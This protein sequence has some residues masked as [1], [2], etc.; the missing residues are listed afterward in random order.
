[1]LFR[2]GTVV[3]V[4]QVFG[5]PKSL[6]AFIAMTAGGYNYQGVFCDTGYMYDYTVGG[7]YTDIQPSYTSAQI[8][9]IKSSPHLATL[10]DDTIVARL[11]TDAYCWDQVQALGKMTNR[12]PFF[13]DYAYFVDLSSTSSSTGYDYFTN[14]YIDY[15]ESY[16]TSRGTQETLDILQISEN[17][18]QG[19]KIGRASCRERV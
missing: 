15:G 11:R 4:E 18:D 6:F 10:P 1:M 2:S 19:S 16:T 12:H 8:D 3:S 17:E 5:S 14:M 7:T 9:T 13:Y